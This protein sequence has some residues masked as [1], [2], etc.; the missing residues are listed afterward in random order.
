MGPPGGVVALVDHGVVGPGAAV[1]ARRSPHADAAVVFVDDPVVVLV[2]GRPP[3]RGE[4]HAPFAV[5]QAL[6]PPSENTKL[7][8]CRCTPY[9]SSM[10]VGTPR[11]SDPS[12]D[13]ARVM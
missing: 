10:T 8:T 11:D 5:E 2:F 6:T 1:V 12:N 13:A 3:A 9:P 4:Q 7:P